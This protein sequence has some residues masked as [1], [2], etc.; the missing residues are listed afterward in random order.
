MAADDKY[1]MDSAGFTQAE[2]DYA[3]A[4]KTYN[5]TLDK[6]VTALDGY[7]GEGKWEGGQANATFTSEVATAKTKLRTIGDN[8]KTNGKVFTAIKGFVNQYDTEV[9]NKVNTM[10]K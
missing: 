3:A 6:I 1:Y 2:T 5:E 4:V 8:I 7:T 10:V 9:S